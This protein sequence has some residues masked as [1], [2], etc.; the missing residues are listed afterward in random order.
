MA[1]TVQAEEWISSVEAGGL[2]GVTTPRIFQLLRDG[3]LAYIRV[4]GR[5]LVD[6]DQVL[7]MLRQKHHR[8]A[9][10]TE[11]TRRRLEGQ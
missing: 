1:S 3:K 6:K 8:A 7:E 11:M 9:I 4:S 10:E 5:V 2:L